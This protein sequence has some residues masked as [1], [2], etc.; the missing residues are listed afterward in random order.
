M[1]HEKINDGETTFVVSYGS[2][3]NCLVVETVASFINMMN[4]LNSSNA[5]TRFGEKGIESIPQNFEFDKCRE[6]K[7]VYSQ[8]IKIILDGKETSKTEQNFNDVINREKNIFKE[9]LTAILKRS[10]D[11]GFTLSETAN[12]LSLITK[13]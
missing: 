7:L 4:Y 5:I 6:Y 13:L 3:T 10:D 1:E 9:A 12:M 8:V 2:K 11:V